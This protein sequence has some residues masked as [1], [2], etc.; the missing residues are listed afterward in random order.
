[1]TE[2]N[3][4][5]TQPRQLLGINPFY[6]AP[7]RRTSP[8]V[9]VGAG[10]GSSYKRHSYRARSTV[11]PRRSGL[12]ALHRDPEVRFRDCGPRVGRI[13]S[14][15]LTFAILPTSPTGDGLEHLLPW[16]TALAPLHFHV[17]GILLLRGT[18]FV[19]TAHV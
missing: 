2:A 5:R 10:P 13:S 6:A 4:L 19:T 17:H 16:L 14:V 8:A 1:M 7:R 18:S 9:F 12:V 3:G 15:L 11:F